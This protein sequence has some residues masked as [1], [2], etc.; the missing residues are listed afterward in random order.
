M[1][2]QIGIALALLCAAATN[3]GFLLKHRGACEAPA[4]EFKHPL[5]S[6]ICLFRSKAFLAGYGVAVVAFTLHV[7]A[8]WFAP[9]SIVQSVISGGLVFLAVLAER[10]F[11]YSL[12]R[13]QW[14]GILLTA[15]V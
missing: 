1:E 10:V 9:I 8:L 5:R 7:G 4:V 3:L 13:R 6:A 2:L 11:G 15:S 14:A 12:G